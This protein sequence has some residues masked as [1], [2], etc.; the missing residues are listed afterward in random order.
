MTI[1]KAIELL[2]DLKEGTGTDELLDHPDAI[3]LAIEALIRVEHTRHET[4]K[5]AIPQLPGETEE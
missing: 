4:P 2:R 1:D 5:F 3:Q